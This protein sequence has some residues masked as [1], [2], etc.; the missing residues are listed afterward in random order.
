MSSPLSLVLIPH[1]TTST[2]F[3]KK[4]CK[5]QDFVYLSVCQHNNL[6]RTEQ[7]RARFDIGETALL[8]SK[9]NAKFSKHFLSFL[10]QNRTQ[11]Y[12]FQIYLQECDLKKERAVAKCKTE[13]TN[14]ALKRQEIHTLKREIQKLK[15][16]YVTD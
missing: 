14:N 16:R 6:P 7:N 10:N 9:T 15:I 8:S 1:P 13:Q 12:G 2:E 4:L 5:G 11:A 3:G